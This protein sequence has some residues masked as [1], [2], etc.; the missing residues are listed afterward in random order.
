MTNQMLIK[1]IQLTLTSIVLILSI[2][3][4]TA[5]LLPEVHAKMIV[6][7]T[8]ILMIFL[9]LFELMDRFIHKN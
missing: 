3:A 2:I 1:K 8:L 5:E 9:C 7:P 6:I 4:L